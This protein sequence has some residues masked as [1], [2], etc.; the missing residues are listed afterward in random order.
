MKSFEDTWALKAKQ[1]GYRSRA[2]YKLDHIDQKY[3]LI[4]NARKVVELGSAPGG[5]SQLIAK[6]KHPLTKCL[7]IDILPMNKVSGIEFH[8]LDLKSDEFIKLMQKFAPNIDVIMSDMSANLSGV[9]V[10]D[11][12]ANF[13]INLFSLSLAKQYLSKNGR[14]LIKTFNNRNL[15]SLKKEFSSFFCRTYT[16]KPP[17]SKTSS[18][19][20][21]LLGL[22]PK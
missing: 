20:V 19:E 13:E 3:D 15:A 16:E 8:Q 6:K 2:T 7:A 11:E 1:E 22:D 14:L 17:A 9:K 10:V 18:S 4:R 21:Y 12:E 5:W